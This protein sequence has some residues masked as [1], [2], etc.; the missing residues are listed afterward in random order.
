M[1]S[2]IVFLAIISSLIFLKLNDISSRNKLNTKSENRLLIAGG[3]VSLFLITNTTLS[4]PESLYWFLA[5]SVLLIGA[6]LCL[7]VLKSEAL[8]FKNLKLRDRIMNVLF[9]GFFIISIHLYL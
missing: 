7:D 4:Y 9:Y 2:T 5:L 8:R 3:L 1:T 6:I